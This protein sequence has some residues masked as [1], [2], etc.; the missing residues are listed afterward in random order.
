MRKAVAERNSESEEFAESLELAIES[1]LDRQW[2]NNTL[3]H[4]AFS[5]PTSIALTD[6]VAGLLY[7][8]Y[9]KAGWCL[10]VSSDYSTTVISIR[11]LEAGE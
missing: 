8:R 10:S 4:L 2:A 6:E 3:G 9:R 7:E 1:E 5:I 11:Q